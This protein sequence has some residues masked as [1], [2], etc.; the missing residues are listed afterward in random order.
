MTI[1]FVLMLHSHL[2]WVLHHGRWPHGS[3]WI[4]EAALDSYLPLIAML[5][6]LEHE[7]VPPPL[8][9]GITPILAAQF[10]SPSFRA[11]LDVYFA[12]RLQTIDEAPESLR[13]TG[14]EHLIP[15]VAYWKLHLLGLRATW[16]RIGKNLISAF[17]RH[18][19]AGRIELIASAATHGFL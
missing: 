3:D 14:D 19:V 15:L 10:A 7:D 13:Q 9:L 11:E 5:E 1:R 4:C 12:H 16:E 6:S 8:T 17:R 18:G 2:P